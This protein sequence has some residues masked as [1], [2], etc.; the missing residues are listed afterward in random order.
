VSYEDAVDVV[1]G[2]SASQQFRLEAAHAHTCIYQDSGSA[3]DSFGVKEV[4]VAAAAA[5]K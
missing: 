3:V 4:T 2:E 5:G 1:K